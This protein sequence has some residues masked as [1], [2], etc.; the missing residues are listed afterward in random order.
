MPI[1]P[2]VLHA[3]ASPEGGRVV[4]VLGAGCS[5]EPPTHIPLAKPIALEAYRR[6][7]ADSELVE[8]E[9]TTTNDLSALTEFI[10]I[11]FGFQRKLVERLPLTKF[12]TATPNEGHLAAAALL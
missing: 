3:I 7:V 11:K 12:R 10:K 1:P 8:G 2:E 9:C 5:F 4:L 6:L